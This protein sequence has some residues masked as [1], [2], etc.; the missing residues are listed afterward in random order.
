MPDVTSLREV[1]NRCSR[2][3]EPD[4]PTTMIVN[5]AVLN[6]LTGTNAAYDPRKAYLVTADGITEIEE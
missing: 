5:G 4:Y 3:I 6:D 1:Y 2:G